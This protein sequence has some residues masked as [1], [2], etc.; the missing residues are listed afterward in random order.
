MRVGILGILM[1]I[2]VAMALK[3][4]KYLSMRTVRLSLTTELMVILIFGIIEI[5]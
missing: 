1:G 5:R 4:D 2:T 3:N